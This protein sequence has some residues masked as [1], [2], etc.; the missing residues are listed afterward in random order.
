MTCLFM[1]CLSVSDIAMAL[2]C[3]LR[4][5]KDNTFSAHKTHELKT[6]LSHQKCAK[7]HV[8]QSGIKKNF[9]G[10][11]PGPPPS[12]EPRLTWRGRDASDA[13]EGRGWTLNFETVDAPLNVCI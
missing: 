7:T 1:L 11:T 10:Y 2:I 3:K 5:T 6:H 13:G 9:R 4:D 12:G 8:R